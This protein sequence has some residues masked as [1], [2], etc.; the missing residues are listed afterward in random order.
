MFSLEGRVVLL[1]GAGGRLGSA[2]SQAI[3]AAGAELVLCGRNASTLEACRARFT[4]PQQARA[5]ACVADVTSEA[6]ITALREFIEHRFGRLQGIVNNAYAGRVGKLEAIEP[7]DFQ[8]ACQ[9]NLIAPFTLVKALRDLL[10]R[11]AQH[12]R[13]SS[14]VL[15]IAS[16]YG[17]VSPYPQVYGESGKNNPVHYGATKGGLIQM[18]RYL[19]CH[20]GA[21]GIRVNSIAPGPFPDVS[22][23]PG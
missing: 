14:S 17:S 4:L 7:V 3:V 5:H 13:S 8:L 12:S 22:V 19:A 9:Y 15:N 21:S 23:D 6:G 10:Q 1:T 11:G 16:M 2:M 18:T 20:L